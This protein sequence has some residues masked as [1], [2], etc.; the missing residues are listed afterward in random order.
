MVITSCTLG[1]TVGKAEIALKEAT[2][3]SGIVLTRALILG[4][5]ETFGQREL[6]A[7]QIAMEGDIR[8][9]LQKVLL[10]L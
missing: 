3:G 8:A 4:F 7:L 6:D 1:D 5:R 2:P 10:E 9:V